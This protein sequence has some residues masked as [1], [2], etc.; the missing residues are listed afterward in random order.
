[1]N[2]DMEIKA[3]QGNEIIPYFGWFND[4]P[5]RKQVDSEPTASIIVNV[6]QGRYHGLLGLIRGVPVGLLVYHMKSE[7]HI[8]F[9]FM[10]GKKQLARFYTALMGYLSFYDIKSFGFESI[11]EPK[12]WN[13]MFPGRIKKIRSTYSFDLAGMFESKSKQKRL[14][15]QGGG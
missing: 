15:I 9:K 2:K 12:L 7:G 4:V 3:V 13:R 6:L 14:N 11:H 5:K 8:D 1:M 10:H